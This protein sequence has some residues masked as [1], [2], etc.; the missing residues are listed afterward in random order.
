MIEKEIAQL[1]GGKKGVLVVVVVG[2]WVGAPE[3][4]SGPQI[5][6]ARAVRNQCALS[7]SPNGANRDYLLAKKYIKP[8][9]CTSDPSR[10]AGY[11]SARPRER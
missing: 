11:E 7:V 4:Q 6:S 8:N 3:K 2:V 5:P 9:S 10:S 1:K